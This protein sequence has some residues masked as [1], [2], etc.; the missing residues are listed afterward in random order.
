MLDVPGER[1]NTEVLTEIF[2]KWTQYI[3]F[4][5]DYKNGLTD[6]ILKLISYAIVLD[7]EFFIVVNKVDLVFKDAALYKKTMSNGENEITKKYNSKTYF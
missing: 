6:K 7:I 4:V 5:I 2:H 3:M 1:K